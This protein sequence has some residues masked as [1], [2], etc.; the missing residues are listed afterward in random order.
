MGIGKKS[1]DSL[2]QHTAA[3]VLKLPTFKLLVDPNLVLSMAETEK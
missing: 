3:T 1:I 2:Q